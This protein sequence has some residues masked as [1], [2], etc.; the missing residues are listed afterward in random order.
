MALQIGIVGLPNAGKSTLFNA[1]TGAGASVANYPFT[2]IE[3]NVGVVAVPDP[4]LERLLEIAKPERAVPATVRFVDIAGLVQ[5]AHRGEGLGNQFL[6]H[7]RDVD[8]IAVVVRCFA[9]PNIAHIADTLDPVQDIGVLLLE[10]VLAD[11]ATTERRLAKIQVMRK[12]QLKDSVL[13]EEEAL[14]N[15]LLTELG[16]GRRARTLGLESQKYETLSA[17][18]LLTAKPLLYVANVGEADLPEGGDLAESVQRLAE[19]EGA[20]SVVLCA[21]LD[22]DLQDWPADEAAAYRQELGVTGSGLGSLIAAGYRLLQLITFFTVVGE[23]EVRAWPIPRG[24]TASHA[25][26]HV[27]T[28]MERGFI[29]AEVVAYDDLSRLESVAAARKAGCLRLE[30]RDYV[31]QDGDVITFRFNVGKT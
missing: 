5:G 24:T 20:E 9:D 4:R 22:A 28:D 26:G 25:A 3:P 21:A 17:L 27:H 1:L 18:N 7:I 8:A 29:R 16:Q 14:L 30:G 13:A 11:V 2:T 12:G 31:V 23:K 6:G 19:R 15:R 10:M